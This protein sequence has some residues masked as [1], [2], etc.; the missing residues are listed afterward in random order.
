MASFVIGDSVLP[1]NSDVA[2]KYF[3]KTEQV[4]LQILSGKAPYHCYVEKLHYWNINPRPQKLSLCSFRVNEDAGMFTSSY[5]AEKTGTPCSFVTVAEN[6]HNMLQ[7]LELNPPLLVRRNEQIGMWDQENGSLSVVCTWRRTFGDRELGYF[8]GAASHFHK[9][10]KLRSYLTNATSWYVEF[11]RLTTTEKEGLSGNRT[12]K[13]KAVSQ[14]PVIALCPPEQSARKLEA[15]IQLARSCATGEEQYWAKWHHPS[16]SSVG[17][18]SSAAV[19]PSGAAAGAMGNNNTGGG[20]ASSTSGNTKSSKKKNK[21][22][23]SNAANKPGGDSAKEMS[24]KSMEANAAIDAAAG[25]ETSGAAKEGDRGGSELEDGSSSAPEHQNGTINDPA[26]SSGVGSVAGTSTSNAGCPSGVASSKSVAS[27]HLD[28][29]TT[30]FSGV[31]VQIGDNVDLDS[32]MEEVE[33][34]AA[35]PGRKVVPKKSR[36]RKEGETSANADAGAIVPEDEQGKLPTENDSSA[37]GV[38]PDEQK[39]EETIETANLGAQ[40]SPTKKGFRKNESSP[41][42]LDKSGLSDEPTQSPGLDEDG[43]AMMEPRVSTGSGVLEDASEEIAE[44]LD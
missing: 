3:T 4:P 24:E 18:S 31:R 13:N 37:A 21:G 23:S 26:A 14:G 27:G 6:T 43:D 15:L 32:D 11:R 44:P 2:R 7:V 39:S 40:E 38:C 10:L 19:G 20:S 5:S 12:K 41:K 17:G 25:Q 16:T 28:T 42:A 36:K 9:T 22:A 29:T 1:I 8:V 34:E 30:L 33:L 35:P